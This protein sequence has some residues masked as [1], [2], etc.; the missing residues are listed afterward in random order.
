[1]L[2]IG[3]AVALAEVGWGWAVP[4]MAFAAL[5]VVLAIWASIP[6]EIELWPGELESVDRFFTGQIKLRGRLLRASGLTLCLA[7]LCLPLPFIVA[8]L[9]SPSPELSLSASRSGPA[10]ALS[11]HADHVSAGNTRLDLKL[12]TDRG[13]QLLGR[14]S[15]PLD[16]TMSL[17]SSLPLAIVPRGAII[18]ASLY[19]NGN[20]LLV[21]CLHLHGGLMG[22]PPI[23]ES[24]HR[25][26]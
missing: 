6:R 17:S 25:P 9:H 24:S 5:T 2:S 18:V 4:A 11:A 26:S 15:E 8:A 21:R 10:L 13:E 16:S 19:R 1:M 14:R 3:G 20:L 12:E 7:L 22:T 23:K